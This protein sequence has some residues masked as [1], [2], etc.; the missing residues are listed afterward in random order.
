MYFTSFLK[1]TGNRTYEAGTGSMTIPFGKVG[2]GPA[3]AYSVAPLLDYKSSPLFDLQVLDT[4]EF[5]CGIMKPVPM[6]TIEYYWSQGWP[7]EMLLYLF[8]KRIEVKDPNGH[9]EEYDNYPGEEEKLKH[10]REQI[11]AGTW[12]I[13]VDPNAGKI[14]EVDA[15]EAAQLKGLIEVQKAG[16]T[17]KPVKNDSTKKAL[18]LAQDK[19]IFKRVP[20]VSAEQPGKKPAEGQ[21]K[22]AAPML[23]SP[24]LQL[25]ANPK[26]FEPPA[27]A[28]SAPMPTVRGVPPL[29]LVLC[30]RLVPGLPLPRHEL[31][32]SISALRRPSSI[33]W[34]RSCARRVY[35]RT[36][37]FW[38]T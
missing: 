23:L 31:V 29:R 27:P 1:L 38:S 13:E 21:P 37:S 11:E 4:Q 30:L 10:F 35:R 25:L 14:G 28:K 36:P 12:T 34:E 18:Y 32:L 7:K 5:T 3:T 22:Q 20:N 33:I 9:V 26:D 8:I 15:R 16:L 17:L 2:T 6:T 24:S 19:Y